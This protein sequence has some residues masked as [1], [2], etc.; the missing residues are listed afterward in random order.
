MPEQINDTTFDVTLSS[1]DKVEIG[2]KE[3][4]DFKPH[5]KLNRWDGECFL[6]IKP[7]GEIE[8]EVEY[9]VE[10]EKV[11]CKYKVKQGE[12]EFEWETEFYALE[13]RVVIAKDKD[14]NDVPFTQ[15]ELGGFEF[16]VFLKEKPPTNKIVLD[17]ETQGLKFYSQP[18]EIAED[19]IAPENV[20]GSI[21]VYHATRT[22]MHRGKA[23]AEKYKCGKAFHIYRPKITDAEGNWVWGELSI[24]EQ[25]STLT[26][27]IPQEFIDG[28]TYPVVIDPTFGYTTLGTTGSVSIAGTSSDRSTMVGI[29]VVLG[30]NGTLSSMHIGSKAKLASETADLFGGVYREN[31]AGAGS[32]DLVASVE[33]LNQAFTTTASF[34][35]INAASEELTADT[36]ILAALA[37]GAD[38]TTS[39]NFIDVMYDDGAVV[40]L[41]FE[42]TYGASGYA[43]RKAEDPWTET[44]SATARIYSI[45]CTYEAAGAE[46]KTGSDTGSGADAKKTGNPLATLAKSDTGSGVEAVP[47]RAITLPESG[48]GLDALYALLAALTKADVGSGV[49]ARL[50]FLVAL[51]QADTGTGA[52]SLLNRFLT[53]I[54][55]GSGADLVLARLILALQT[56]SGVDLSHL[57]KELFWASDVGTGAENSYLHILV[58][59]KSSSDIGSG[60]D[61]ST[62]AALLQR[63]EAGAGVEAV[64][65]RALY[66]KEYP[67]GALDLAKVLTAAI[68]GTETGTGAEASLIAYYQKGFD[69]GSGAE[70]SILG[71]LFKSGDSGVGAEAITLVAAMLASDSGQSVE[72]VLSYLRKLVDSGVGSEVVN[73]IGAAGRAMKLIT[74]LRAYSDLRVY[75]RPYSDLKVYTSEVKKQ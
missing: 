35:T 15:N 3:A 49:D 57:F 14:G 41:Y 67:T 62:L 66:A 6:A 9:E 36:Y 71:Y 70:E 8:E 39:S 19:S 63:D 24:D 40:N 18:Y 12:F 13:P 28:A 37:N 58:G 48:S 33:Q 69:A 11:K 17:I 30:V 59:V 75:T 65:A 64:V 1:G 27:T 38:L 22:N 72:T 29:A 5:I 60:V 16:E 73:I 46:E 45:Y 52:D 20:K 51:A 25:A 50:S 42:T 4:I 7:A 56:S 21:A 23:D 61:A 53:L 44:A 68:A 34:K 43:T 54:D 32:H 47:G 31:S 55:S 2:D 26:I 74:Y 10:E